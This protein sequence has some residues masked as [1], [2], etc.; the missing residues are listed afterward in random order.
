MLPGAGSLTAGVPQV[1][2]TW[3]QLVVNMQMMALKDR[4]QKCA[5]PLEVRT[6]VLA[7]SK[8]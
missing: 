3:S 2:H 8:L 7:Q 5:M 6:G 1:P 4:R